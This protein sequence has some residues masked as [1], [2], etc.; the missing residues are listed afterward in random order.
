MTSFL[1]V[2]SS[3]VVFLPGSSGSGPTVPSEFH[4]DINSA[5]LSDVAA[6]SGD[7]RSS[8]ADDAASV[9]PKDTSFV[10]D[11]VTGTVIRELVEF[12]VEAPAPLSDPSQMTI[13]KR[14]ETWIS[15]SV[16]I[17]GSIPDLTRPHDLK[18]LVATSSR[19]DED[20]LERNPFGSMDTATSLFS[21]SSGVYEVPKNI[22]FS[23]TSWV[24][25]V[26]FLGKTF[27][28]PAG[29]GSDLRVS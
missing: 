6:D 20:G 21:V 23:Q 9:V 15:Q 4:H 19:R 25:S 2:L 10:H 3:V 13:T 8:G 5:G 17:C 22:H 29:V 1:R 12:W 26:I 11:P 27:L 14:P 7:N 18:I 28:E 24:P 16:H